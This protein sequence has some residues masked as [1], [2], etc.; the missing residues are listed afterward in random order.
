MPT[1]LVIEKKKALMLYFDL[2]LSI[3]V[4]CKVFTQLH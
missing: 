2:I 3:E 4:L 1:F